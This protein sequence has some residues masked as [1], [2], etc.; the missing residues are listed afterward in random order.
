M[1]GGGC[2]VQAT[3]FQVLYYLLFCLLEV[4]DSICHIVGLSW[5]FGSWRSRRLEK[6]IPYAMIVMD[7][8]DDDP[9]VF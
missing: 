1:E 7:P 2:G 8:S 9:A 6:S 3:S 4:D 5:D